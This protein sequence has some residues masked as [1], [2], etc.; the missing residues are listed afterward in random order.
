MVPCHVHSHSPAFPS[1]LPQSPPWLPIAQQPRKPAG[2]HSP[3][4]WDQARKSKDQF[5]ERTGLP[6][7]SSLSEGAVLYPLLSQPLK[8][9][10]CRFPLAPLSDF[11][12]VLLTILLSCSTVFLAT[13]FLLQEKKHKAGLMFPECPSRCLGHAPGRSWPDR[14]V[15]WPLQDS[16]TGPVGS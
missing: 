6:Q 9:I 2:A 3:L 16:A 10:A 8:R 1:N 7:A 15:R 4:M 5:Q 13:K 14:E 11:P 12:K